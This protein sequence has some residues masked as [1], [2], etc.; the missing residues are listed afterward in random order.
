MK[1]FTGSIIIAVVSYIAAVSA[2]AETDPAIDDPCFFKRET[3]IN[4]EFKY[5]DFTKMADKWKI[6]FVSAIILNLSAY[7]SG[8]SSSYDYA[9]A[10]Y[11]KICFKN[12]ILME[13][14]ANYVDL[15]AV[16]HK[17][18]NDEP[19]INVVHDAIK[20]VCDTIIHP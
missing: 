18:S 14:A 17:I 7:E 16:R 9:R 20:E 10:Q 4:V 6:G 5:G 13:T 19:A 2:S 1:R 12:G 8:K 15:Y 11:Y 3:C